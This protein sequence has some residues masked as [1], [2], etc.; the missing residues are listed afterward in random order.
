MSQSEAVMPYALQ[1]RERG[2]LAP[3]PLL[4]RRVL[5][6]DTFLCRHLRCTDPSTV[7]TTTAIML[8][9]AINGSGCSRHERARAEAHGAVCHKTQSWYASRASHTLISAAARQEPTRLVRE[10]GSSSAH[11]SGIATGTGTL[12]EQV[13]FPHRVSASLLLPLVVPSPRP[14]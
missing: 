6:Q 11:Q 13:A 7:A 10:P 2:M 5:R 4:T 12:L 1:N 14:S 8:A 3:G 9:K